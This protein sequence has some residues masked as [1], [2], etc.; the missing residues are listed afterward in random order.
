M[1]NINAIVTQIRNEIPSTIL[2]GFGGSYAYGTQIEG[3]SD[4]DVRGIYMNPLDEMIGCRSDSETKEIS[5]QD[6]VLYSIKK[7]IHLLSQCNPNTIEILGLDEYLYCDEVG[8][9]IVD[10]KQL[11]ISKKA[12]FTFGQY[13]KAQLNRLVNK[14]GKA[15]GEIVQNEERSLQKALNAMRIDPSKFSIKDYPEKGLTVEM[16]MTCSLQEFVKIYQAVDCVH[17]YYKNSTRNNKAIEHKKLSKHMMH[18]LRLYMMGIDILESGEIV[19]RR[20]KSCVLPSG[21]EI[22]EHDLLMSIRNGDFLE[23]D[24][25]TP[26]KEFEEYLKMYQTLFDKAVEN[27]RLP[28]YPDISKINNLMMDC[29]RTYYF[30]K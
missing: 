28:E 10:N 14:S 15:K 5:G 7:M 24:Q 19:T 23:A 21:E 3:V 6:T 8:Q 27:S 26:T 30:I 12:A 22:K 4:I 20:D 17:D 2:L 13:A 18:L 9:M 25:K 29:V 1:P 16:N 11:F